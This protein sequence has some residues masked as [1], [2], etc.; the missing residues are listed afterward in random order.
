MHYYPSVS[1]NQLARCDEPANIT[2]ISDNTLIRYPQDL[3]NTVI[4]F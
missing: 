4:N 3:L 1:S 2:T